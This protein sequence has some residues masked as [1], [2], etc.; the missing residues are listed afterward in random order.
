VGA[1]TREQ[2]RARANRRCEYCGLP[3]G[4]VRLPHQVDHIIPP[5]HIGS[6]ELYNLA[7]ACFYCNNAKGTDIATVDFES[8]ER[9]WLYNPRQ[10]NW[11]ENFQLETDGY[12][13]GLSHHGQSIRPPF[14]NEHTTND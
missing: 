2:V 3:E 14:G 13:T 11:S 12:V 5:R 9:V 10:D 8:K 7:W 6:D 1:V 4:I